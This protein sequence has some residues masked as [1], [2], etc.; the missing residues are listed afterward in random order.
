M[1]Q[2][3]D[4]HLESITWQH[5]A[6]TL[7]SASHPE[8][9]AVAAPK[10]MLVLQAPMPVLTFTTEGFQPPAL[11]LERL[12]SAPSSSAPLRAGSTPSP[13]KRR[14]VERRTSSEGGPPVDGPVD[15]DVE[16]P[17]KRTRQTVADEQRALAAERGGVE[18]RERG[19]KDAAPPHTAGQAANG[20]M[21]RQSRHHGP[22]STATAPPAPPLPPPLLPPLPHRLCFEDCSCPLPAPS[23]EAL[24]VL[25][26]SLMAFWRRARQEAGALDGLAC[27]LIQRVEAEVCALWPCARL[28]CFG[29]RATGLAVASSDIDLVVTRVDGLEDGSAAVEGVNLVELQLRTLRRLLPRLNSLPS[30]T[31]AVINKSAV[32][33]I[34]LSVRVPAASPTAGERVAWDGT[35]TTL[36]LDISIATP[37]HRGLAAAE[38]V[39]TSHVHVHVHAHAQVHAHVRVHVHVRVRVHVHVH[40]HE[41][42]ACA[43]APHSQV[44]WLHAQLPALAPLVSVLKELLLRH[45]LKS[46]FTGGLSSIALV[47]MIARFLLDR[48]AMRYARPPPASLPPPTPSETAA[49]AAR[50]AAAAARQAAEEA[51]QPV[52]APPAASPGSSAERAGLIAASVPLRAAASAAAASAA[53]ESPSI[54]QLLHE[55]LSFYGTVFEPARHAVLGGVGG[56]RVPPPGCGFVLRAALAPLLEGSSPQI[57]RHKARGGASGA[58]AG[59]ADVTDPAPAEPFGMDPLVCID[60]ACVDNNTGKSCYRVG[61]VRRLMAS[62]A[63]VAAA[64]AEAEAHARRAGKA[65][66]S[67]LGLFNDVLAAAKG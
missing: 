13:G 63:Q 21:A 55:L 7:T 64:A 22:P 11:L 38:H 47:T 65:S 36:L 59:A 40:V 17:R 67:P 19:G 27:T 34:N 25:D 4:P 48:R 15:D 66:T 61:Q 57:T 45:H 6:E 60:P 1:L 39:R 20:Q 12:P 42:C 53:A 5:G 31:S 28:V 23:Q 49:A 41:P 8:Q 14:S 56:M 62:A 33:V 54:G 2:K 50:R 10:K 58:P 30:V 3:L 26:Q 18:R 44:R 29:S 46:A 32:P 9:A 51:R 52:E 43:C 37:S 16:S 24:E 35:T